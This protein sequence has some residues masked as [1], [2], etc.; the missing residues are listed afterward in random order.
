MEDIL[1]RA[2]ILES[3]MAEKSTQFSKVIALR[4]TLRT[5]PFL[6]T[7]GRWG[8]NPLDQRLLMVG[9]RA[10]VLVVAKGRLD[11]DIERQHLNEIMSIS[12]NTPID[13]LATAVSHALNAFSIQNSNDSSNSSRNIRMNAAVHAAHA[14]QM[15]GDFIAY[16][17]Y[18]GEAIVQ[19]WDD[20]E[21]DFFSADRGSTAD[22]ILN[23]PLRSHWP[24]SPDEVNWQKTSSYLRNNCNAGIWS[25]WGNRQLDGL[26]HSFANFD[27]V[28]ERSFYK[29]LSEFDNDW[30]G[31]EP[32]IVNADIQA[33]VEALRRPFLP[34]EDELE[35]NPRAFTFTIDDEG[36]SDLDQELLPNGLQGD[37]DER[38]N[39]SEILR[40]IDNAALATAG[41][42]NAKDMAEPTDLLRESVGE[43]V[44]DLRP[45]LFILRAREVIRQVAE[46]ESGES[47]NPQLS[48]TQRDAYLPLV[49]ALKM[50]AE[51]S[52]KLAELWHGKFGQTG[53]PLT[54]EVLDLIAS[55]FRASGQTTK[56]AQE[57]IEAS[58]A[59]VSPNA[60]DDDPA[61]IAAS[62]TSRN[63]VRRMGGALKRAG[64]GAKNIESVVSLGE[65]AVSIWNL[66]R[67][68]L[69]DGEIIAR[70]LSFFDGG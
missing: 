38:D 8:A 41:D 11:Q 56:L 59:Q 26:S 58:N 47:M 4:A 24:K 42:T 3:R 9:L 70:I 34:S 5:I 25:E 67:G 48:E 52:P 23:S 43:T 18:K 35:Q 63:V 54:R 37:D 36:R 30:W 61:R 2:K 33:M 39:H 20:V 13:H 60:P 45:R 31:R 62:E 1:S 19:F 40:L 10:L 53:E 32:S 21:G 51:F 12:N 29:Q 55:A 6:S 65:R 49:E 50:M 17:D 64:D 28:A 27:D 66:L 16:P 22:R 44:E 46:R 68:R 7:S 69:P 15:A 14:V 57:I